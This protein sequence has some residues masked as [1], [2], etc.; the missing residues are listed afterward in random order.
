VA[1][2]AASRRAQAAPMPLAA[3]VTSAVGRRGPR[4]PSRHTHR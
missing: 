4:S 1:P 3:P 2:A